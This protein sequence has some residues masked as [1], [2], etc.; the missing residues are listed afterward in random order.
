VS[1]T[2]QPQLSEYLYA[3]SA[4]DGADP[5]RALDTGDDPLRNGEPDG[6]LGL[7]RQK[8]AAWHDQTGGPS[9]P[10]AGNIP[11]GTRDVLRGADF[12]NGSLQG[13]AIDSGVWAVS[14]G[15]LQ[16]GAASLGLEATAVYNLDE[17]LPIY[18]ELQ[19]SIAAQKPTGGWGA[20]SF[21]LFDYWSPTDFKFAGIDIASNKMV[22]GH[23]TATGWVYDAQSPFNGS[24]H[25]DTLYN[26]LVAVNG[27]AITVS[28]NGSQALSY[29]AAARV[30]SDGESV[31][32]NKGFVGFGSNNSKG[33]LDN[34]AVQVLPAGNTLDSTEY[35]EDGT[36]DRFAGSPQSG[37]WSES[38]GRYSATAAAGTFALSSVDLGSPVAPTSNVDVNATLSASGIGGV[39]FDAY[40]AN[41]FKFAALD[42]A[43]QRIV[44][45]HVDPRRGWIV[46]TSF[47]AALVAGVDY[48]LDVSLKESVA[49]V[50]LNGSLLGSFVFNSAVA[51]GKVGTLTRGGTSSFDRFQIRTDERAF[52]G[53][54][55]PTELRVG[56]ATVVEGNA[57]TTAATIVLSLTAP[58]ATATTVGWTTVAGT[59]AAGSDFQAVPSGTVTFAAGSSTAQIVVNVVGDTVFEPDEVF[60]V[61]LTSWAGFNLADATG[62]VT[63]QNDDASVSVSTTDSSGAEQLRD[64]I[65]F[66]VTRVG[67]LSAGL[68]ANLAWSG[69]AAFGADY[70][71]AATGAALGAN[72]TT[73]TFAAGV[74]TAT[75]T[76]TPVDDTTAEPN[77]TVTMTLTAGAYAVGIP[78]SASGSI[79]DNDSRTVS[80]GN[81][82][83]T[84]GD[85]STTTIS[86][87]VTLSSAATAAVTV[88][89]TTVAGTAT[90]GTD[91]Q[92]RTATLT[93]AAGSTTASFQVTIVNDKVAEPT[94]TFSVVLS[95]V[96]GPATIG[97][98]SGTVTIVDNDGALTAS[99]APAA[100]QTSDP[101][102]ASR[103]AEAVAQGEA[104]WSA[105]LPAA[106]FG[107]IVFSI[108]D[109]PGLQLGST[110]GRTIAIDPTAAG[111]GWSRMDLLTV[112]LH[113]LGHALGYTHDDADELGVMAGLLA[114]IRT[115]PSGGSSLVAPTRVPLRPVAATAI[116]AGP[117]PALAAPTRPAIHAGAARAQRHHRLRRALT[118]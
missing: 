30:L 102:T 92:S 41:D 54:V 27:T 35:F 14:N 1:R 5:T 16:V 36:A 59:A 9:D 22:V 97:N 64:P 94:E 71:V 66:T 55:A 80:V 106:D 39:A 4:S 7:V 18:Y 116:S 33:V 72:A 98:G 68:V 31:G 40:S 103:L 104:L 83:V 96:T 111:W 93:F 101:L 108:A 76:V 62:A 79:A 17:Y 110:L 70:T 21:I 88:V 87:F 13:F 51:D 38:A 49:S 20:N 42:V 117:A 34:I 77:E 19:A 112:V 86:V 91:F 82:S 109:L 85:R 37:T 58:A 100:V 44:I 29:T 67:N 81:V 10:Q 26:V 63:I 107:G 3:L 118:A 115:S 50:S 47:A 11:G 53:Y 12:N 23:R 57:G 95:N 69:T 6:E 15:Q 65:V 56:D 48:V 24:L 60:A 2:V 78:A 28:V 32:L 52:S 105:E 61:K 46:Q 25:S 99:L 113:E 114:P 89:A 43:G 84:E 8:D 90:A 74:A 45:G 75:V 73:L